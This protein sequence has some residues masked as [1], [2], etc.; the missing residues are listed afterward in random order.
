MVLQN[1][2]IRVG[3][4]SLRN[5]HV[6]LWWP[7]DMNRHIPYTFLV[8]LCYTT[9]LIWNF[10]TDVGIVLYIHNVLMY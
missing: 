4:S 9:L 6:N 1:T 5:Y 8:T 3:I 7:S 2:I 10:L